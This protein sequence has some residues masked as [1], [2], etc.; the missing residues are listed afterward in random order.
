ML[1]ARLHSGYPGGQ[2]CVCVC[3]H[4]WSAKIARPHMNVVVAELARYQMRVLVN[5][6][7]TWKDTEPQVDAIL[8]DSE[9]VSAGLFYQPN[10]QK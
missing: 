4:S 10:N 9:Q 3:P 8:M 7:C 6:P 1:E 2:Q 5:G